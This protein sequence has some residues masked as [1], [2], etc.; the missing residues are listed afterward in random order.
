MSKT[1]EDSNSSGGMPPA[2]ILSPS[3][4]PGTQ[5][6]SCKLNGR[7]YNIWSQERKS[8]SEY[9]SK[10]KSLWDELNLHLDL[11]ACTY[12][13]GVQL[14]AH[15]EKEKVHRF[16]IGLNPEFSIIRSQILSM[17][18]LLNANGAHSMASHDEAQRLIIQGRD[19]S[20]EVMGFAVK[21]TN[22]FN[23]G[24]PN[25]GSNRGDFKPRGRPFCDYC[26]QNGHSRA[27]CYQLHGY[28]TSDQSN[29][30]NPKGNSTG[31]PRSGGKFGVS[32]FPV[33]EQR[34][35]NGGVG[36]GY[37]HLGQS[38][39]FHSGGPSQTRSA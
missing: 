13:T 25:F 15:K 14:V 34:S 10:L 27:T 6:I 37:G 21:T 9:Y 24:N 8:V 18:P 3:D 35:G 12:D 2:Y 20:S 17:D 31:Q 1:T 26:G 30:R 39:N 5:L 33:P 29:Q 7:N 38:G 22:D 11:P 36:F 32:S 4:G 23:G 19:S 16:L 28:L